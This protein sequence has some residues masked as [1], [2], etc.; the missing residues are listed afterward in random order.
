MLP[1]N[2]SDRKTVGG[3]PRFMTL[4]ALGRVGG[5]SDT[6]KPAR[7]RAKAGPAVVA[8]PDASAR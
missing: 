6:G 5:G 3:V 1:A 8:A 7:S 4:E 2:G